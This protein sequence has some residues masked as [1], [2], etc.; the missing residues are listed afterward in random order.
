MH[1]AGLLVRHRDGDVPEWRGR[2]LTNT[3]FGL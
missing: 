3:G 1:A 2:D